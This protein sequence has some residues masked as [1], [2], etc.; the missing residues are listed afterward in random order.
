MTCWMS[1]YVIVLKSIV[2]S[3]KQVIIRIMT[4]PGER[5]GNNKCEASERAWSCCYKRGTTPWEGQ[6]RGSFVDLKCTFT[7]WCTG[8]SLVF[9]N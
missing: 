7:S 8:V 3:S 2:F 4:L 5:S 6:T 1:F 9:S